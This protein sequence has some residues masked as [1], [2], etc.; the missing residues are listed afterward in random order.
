MVAKF[1]GTIFLV[2]QQANTGLGR[3]IFQVSKSH[4]I[5]HTHGRIPL[6]SWSA[7]RRVR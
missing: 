2:A 3:L 6:D 1:N 4:T 7:C 5:R